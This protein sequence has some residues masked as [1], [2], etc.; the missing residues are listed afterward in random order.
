MHGGGIDNPL[1]SYSGGNVSASNRQFLHANHQGSIIAASNST[2]DAS[3]IN[4]YDSY[5]VPANTNQGRFGYTGQL[6]LP[7]IGLNYYKA[8]I[9]HPKLGRFL[10][11]D[12]VGYEDQMNLYAYVGNDPVNNIDPTGEFLVG[13][14]IGA[15]FDIGIQVALMATSDHQFSVSNVVVSAAG[16]A[17]GVGLASKVSQ[18]SKLAGF[19]SNIAGDAAISAGAAAL[20]GESVTLSGVAKDVLLGQSAGVSVGKA[21]NGK[22]ANSASNNLLGKQANRAQ[23]IANNPKVG[24]PA[25]R[26]R[27]ADNAAANHRST[28]AGQQSRAGTVGANTANGLEKIRTCANNNDC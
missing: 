3:Y 11:T 20:K 17:L 1:V 19:S 23:R 2:G 15:A 27:Q 18:M 22:I 16:G 9:Y 14:L 12:P 13:A 26:Q 10:Q 7:E 4:L 5:G 21:V 6:N 24:R 28:V 25:A 8:R